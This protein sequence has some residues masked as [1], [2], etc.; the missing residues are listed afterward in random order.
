MI[1]LWILAKRTSAAFVASPSEVASG[2][3][4]GRTHGVQTRSDTVKEM[5]ETCQDGLREG[6]AMG[7]HRQGGMPAADRADSAAR[8]IR[9]WMKNHQGVEVLQ[10]KKCGK[11]FFFLNAKT[12]LFD[13]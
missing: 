6:A 13:I 11:G 1:R 10:S 9:I 4:F 12:F 2:S 7:E 5:A 8:S 3:A